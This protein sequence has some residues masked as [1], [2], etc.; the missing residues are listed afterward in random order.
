MGKETGMGSLNDLST[1]FF[2]PFTINDRAQQFRKQPIEARKA[3][4]CFALKRLMIPHFFEAILV[5]QEGIV[6]ADD[7]DKAHRLGLNC[8]MGL[9][10]LMGLIGIDIASHVAE[11]LRQE[12]NKKLKWVSPPV[13]KDMITANRLG[14]KTGAGCCYYP[15]K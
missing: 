4:P 15:N 5:F 13:L 3:I 10:E 12:M 1:L 14:M 7:I 9:F 6:S 8:P 2:G 11:Y